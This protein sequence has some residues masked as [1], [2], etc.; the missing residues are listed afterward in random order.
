MDC[1]GVGFDNNFFSN[2]FCV[3]VKSRF[4]FKLTLTFPNIYTSVFQLFAATEPS[5]NVCVALG[6]PCNDTSVYI[7]TT[8]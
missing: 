7:A 4:E 1:R 6:T 2:F 8:A 5:E 3:H